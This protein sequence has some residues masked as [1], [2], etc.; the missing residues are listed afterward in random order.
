MSDRKRTA[1]AVKMFQKRTV[2]IFQTLSRFRSSAVT[3]FGV[4]MSPAGADREFVHGQLFARGFSLWNKVC[5]QKYDGPRQHVELREEH[6]PPKIAAL[7][8]F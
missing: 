8:G 4:F 7:E 2:I 3:I 1:T 5:H 6:K